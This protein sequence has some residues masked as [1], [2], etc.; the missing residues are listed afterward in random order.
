MIIYSEGNTMRY[1]LAGSIHSFVV[2]IFA[3][4]SLALL[5]ACQPSTI[6]STESLI[7][8]GKLDSAEAYLTRRDQYASV[9]QYERAIEDYNQAINRKPDYAEAYNNRGAAFMAN[10][11]P[12]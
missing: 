5:A 4:L 3:I 6:K 10:G 12:D 9:K 1:K 2:T 11:F 8:P 7:A